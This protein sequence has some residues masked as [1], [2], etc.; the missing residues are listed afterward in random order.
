[1]ADDNKFAGNMDKAQAAAAL[2]TAVMPAFL[3]LFQGIWD[4]IHRGDEKKPQ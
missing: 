1:M 4:V 2:W 3:Q